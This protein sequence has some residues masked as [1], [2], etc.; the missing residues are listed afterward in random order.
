M[1][2]KEKEEIDPFFC[3][4]VLQQILQKHVYSLSIAETAGLCGA[5]S[6]CFNEANPEKWDMTKPDIEK[7]F[8]EAVE[9]D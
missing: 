2:Y 3:A 8:W 4:K 1:I 9:D 6:I 7:M 5:I